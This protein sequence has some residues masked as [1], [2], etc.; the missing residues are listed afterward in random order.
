MKTYSTADRDNSKRSSATETKK[1][2]VSS[3]VSEVEEYQSEDIVQRKLHA[4][5][6]NSLQVQK[7]GQIQAMADDYLSQN[8]TVVQQKKN[9]TGLPDHLKTGIENLS[10]YTMDDVKVHYNS[11]EPAQLNAHA[12]AQG[13]DIHLAP[14]QEKHLPHE[15]WHVVQQKQG[16][17]KP[18]LQMKGKVNINDDAGLE[19]EA[20]VMGEK[21]IMQRKSLHFP[22]TS[23]LVLNNTGKMA[24]IQLSGWANKLIGNALSDLVF[25]IGGSIAST[26][27]PVGNAPR[28]GPLTGRGFGSFME[29]HLVAGNI[30][31]GTPTGGAPANETWEG[32]SLRRT[33]SGE[34]LYF[35]AHL[36][37][38][39]LGGSGDDW[40]NL[41]PLA[42]IAN[43]RHSN[44][45]E[46]PVKGAANMPGQQVVYR[47]RPVY[48]SWPWQWPAAVI[49]MLGTPA[50]VKLAGGALGALAKLRE[51][52]QHIPSVLQCDWWVT[53]AAG[54]TSA[55]S[56]TIA[57]EYGDTQVFVSHGGQVL[58]MTNEAYIWNIIEQGLALILRGT[59]LA[60]PKL[61]SAA[62]Q[63][64]RVMTVEQLSILLRRLVGSPVNGLRM[65]IDNA[66]TTAAA[67]A[68]VICEKYGWGG[69]SALILG[70]GG[71]IPG[72]T[73]KAPV[74]VNRELRQ[75]N[76]S[77]HDDERELILNPQVRNR[78]PPERLTYE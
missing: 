33:S 17:V 28:Y 65:L 47:V 73:R 58:D 19:K 53:T 8:K 16:R 63:V 23:T 46:E 51:A 7:N 52:E 20:D 35:Q 25:N 62:Y 6:N 4:I 29:A 49:K 54:Q 64:V 76:E 41:V 21:A 5:A 31:M 1:N 40:S 30:H 10:G 69:I 44:T 75:V 13:T 22:V 68:Q 14:G 15:A 59:L 50:V 34:P 55:H 70:I 27:L 56:A 43:G 66:A 2:R 37:N 60:Y 67:G 9:N 77:L 3:S 48:G 38:K 11:G 32:L 72:G 42:R 61:D 78:N 45:V 24:P 26:L 71:K 18:T 39:H 74:P 36:L 57:Q 12:Y